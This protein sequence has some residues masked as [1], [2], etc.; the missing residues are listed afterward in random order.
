MEGFTPI[1]LAVD[2]SFA[3]LFIIGTPI[4]IT[5]EVKEF[6]AKH[7]NAKTK[8][9]VT[10]LVKFILRQFAL[11][12]IGLVGISILLCLAYAFWHAW[13]NW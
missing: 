7:K 5:K 4:M 10:D 11:A 9:K 3:L 6:R 2:T 1:F 12:S 13:P 8:P